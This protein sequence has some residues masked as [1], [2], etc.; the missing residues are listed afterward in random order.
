MRALR[1][2]FYLVLK[3]QNAPGE[4]RAPAC[5]VTSL[6]QPGLRL[7]HRTGCEL[8]GTPK[9]DLNI[10][11]GVRRSA[12][13]AGGLYGHVAA[14]RPTPLQLAF[15]RNCRAE[16]DGCHLIDSDGIF[17][18]TETAAAAAAAAH[19]DSNKIDYRDSPMHAVFPIS[20]ESL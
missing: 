3:S 16:D 4:A 20:N 6:I 13:T 2:P 8:G 14:R 17:I 11:V 15:V 19:R 10:G 5:D 1:V 7:P 12:G 18:A 9:S